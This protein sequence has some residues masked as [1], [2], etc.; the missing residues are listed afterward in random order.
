MKKSVC[1]FLFIL[2]VIIIFSCS[3]GARTESVE[4]T[5]KKVDGTLT[6][7][8][9]LMDKDAGYLLEEINA[10]RAKNESLAVKADS[11]F[12]ASAAACRLIDSINQVQQALDTSEE[13]IDITDKLL[14]GTSLGLHLKNNLLSVSK[15]CYSS[16]GDPRQKPALDSS[17]A[18]IN[19]IETLDDW[20]KRY[21]Y[22][23]PTVAGITLLNKFKNDCKSATV[24]SLDLILKELSK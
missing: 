9:H 12:S 21:F 20:D 1:L 10:K 17:F 7:S 19:E 23:T 2:P 5:F 4:N 11:V 22:M 13:R 16:L 8:S 3:E 15:A 6:S 24:Y 14:L 18:W